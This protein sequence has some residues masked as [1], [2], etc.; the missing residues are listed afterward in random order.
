MAAIRHAL[1]FKSLTNSSLWALFQEGLAMRGSDIAVLG[2]GA[3]WNGV[4]MKG[5]HARHIAKKLGHTGVVQ[6]IDDYEQAKKKAAQ[7]AADAKAR[8]QREAE[9]SKVR[10]GSGGRSRKAIKRA[11]SSYF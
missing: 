4:N 9:D 11:L 10:P 7:E 6:A 3:H 5:L 1:A 8:A 2:H